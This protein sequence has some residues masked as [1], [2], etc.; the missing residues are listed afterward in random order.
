MHT[1]ADGKPVDQLDWLKSITNHT[2]V[3]H[4]LVGPYTLVDFRNLE[5]QVSR[6]GRDVHFSRY[7]LENPTERMEYVG[8]LR[9]LLERLPL[10][11]EVNTWLERWRWFGELS[12]GCVGLLKS[13]LV[14]TAT[15]TLASGGTELTLE[16]LQ[17]NV[18][19]PG[20]R[21]T[22]EMNARAGEHKLAVA[23]AESQKLEQELWGRSAT[24]PS[25]APSVATPPP[26]KKR[27]GRKPKQDPTGG[28]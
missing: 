25:T 4:I 17:A 15:A 3:L 21:I 27:P 26:P 28:G 6:R 7:H 11:C 24:T 1:D 23:L 13:W 10:T 16:E 8:A 20:Q 19:D 5:P 18:L 22:I 14:D 9:Y 12:L 2:G